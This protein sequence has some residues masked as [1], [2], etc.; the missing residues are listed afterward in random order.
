MNTVLFRALFSIPFVCLSFYLSA[1]TITGV[2]PDS[3][4]Q[5]QQALQVIISGTNLDFIQGTNTVTWIKQGA[6]SIVSYSTQVLNS[7][8]VRSYFNFSSTASLGFY[9]VFLGSPDLSS[10]SLPNGFEVLAEL[11]VLPP[12]A[13]L[14]PAN[15]SSTTSHELNFT[16]TSV[17]NVLHYEYQLSYSPSFGSLIVENETTITGFDETLNNGNYYWRVRTANNA[18]IYGGWS[19]VYHFTINDAASLISITPDSAYQGQTLPVVIS[20]VNLDFT[21]GSATFELTQ[22]SEIMEVPCWIDGTFNGSDFIST[23]S[24]TLS[25]PLTAPTGLYDLS[26]NDSISGLLSLP[27]SFTVLPAQPPTAAPVLISP[28]NGATVNTT[29]IGFDWTDIS[30]ILRYELMVD[31]NSDFSSPVFHFTNLI[32]SSYLNQNYS[33]VNGVYYFKVRTI[34]LSELPGAWSGANSFTVSATPQLVEIQPDNGFTGQL[35]L[36]VSITGVNT[37]FVQGTNTVD[38]LLQQNSYSIYPNGQTSY[39]PFEANLNLDIP[40]GAPTGYYDLIENSQTDGDLYMYNAFYIH[41][42]NEYSGQVYIDENNN[43]VFDAGDFIH[44]QAIV[45][46]SPYYAFTQSDGLFHGYLPQGNFTLSVANVSSYFTCVPSSHTL[47]F[48]GTGVLIMTI[49]LL[50]SLCL[51][52][53]TLL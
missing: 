37:H 17:A 42:G 11:P 35:G 41:A 8:T 51:I 47:N 13:L 36:S 5:G 31:D 26:I 20:G 14:L 29:V 4:Y 22:G 32:P 15:N 19:G 40:P 48:P 12:P 43:Q 9:D 21:Q 50:C 3:A 1:Q 24:G 44:P 46:V 25:V 27:Q 28:A 16:W 39:N 45:N 33:F 10:I 34:N 53:M 38:F 23:A 7:T 18:T 49:I 6:D 30:T 2:N 52:S